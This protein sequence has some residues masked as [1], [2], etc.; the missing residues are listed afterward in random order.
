MNKCADYVHFAYFSNFKAILLFSFL[1]FKK[2]NSM[3]LCVY[4][5]VCGCICVCVCVQGDSLSDLWIL[6]DLSNL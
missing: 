2:S 5:Y 6:N 1:K 4:L 3:A